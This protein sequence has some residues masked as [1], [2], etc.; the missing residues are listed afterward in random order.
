MRWRTPA[1][2]AGLTDMDTQGAR[3][4]VACR[5]ARNTPPSAVRPGASPAVRYKG[6]R[7]M[8]LNSGHLLR[9]TASSRS[10][11]SPSI[12][13]R[14]CENR[15]ATLRASASVCT[16]CRLSRSAVALSCRSARGCGEDARSEGRALPRVDGTSTRAHAQRARAVASETGAPPPPPV[17]TRQHCSALR[18][19]AHQGSGPRW[20][21]S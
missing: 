19:R 7:S 17:H 13:Y 9:I 1:Q 21:P 20:R 12:M 3:T 4:L 16:H 11:S 14:C 8:Y 10:T 5:H 18:R 15:R 2:Q 6:S